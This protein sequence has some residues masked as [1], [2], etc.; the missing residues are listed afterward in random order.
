MTDIQKAILG[1]KDAAE[2]L[3]AAGVMV[4]CPWCKSN[5]IE[6]DDSFSN[7]N[8]YY[9]ICQNCASSGPSG[10]N[11]KEAIQNWNTRSPILTPEQINR[12]EE[13]THDE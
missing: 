5:N 9:G 10:S 6:I 7:S 12:L 8:C 4:P 3:T 2:R 1:D 13:A 11:E